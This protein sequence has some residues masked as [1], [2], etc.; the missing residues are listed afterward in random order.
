MS[1]LTLADQFLTKSQLAFLRVGFFDGVA[2]P[3]DYTL[4]GIGVDLMLPPKNKTGIMN[5]DELPCPLTWELVEKLFIKGTEAQGGTAVLS[6][7][8]LQ[9]L[10]VGT[11]LDTNV[12]LLRRVL[13]ANRGMKEWAVVSLALWLAS[14]T[15]D[16]LA[17]LKSANWLDY[18]VLELFDL[19]KP[20]L[21]QLRRT[22]HVVGTSKATSRELANKL[23]KFQNILDRNSDSADAEAEKYRRTVNTP[24]H[25]MPTKDGLDRC[26]W[27][28]SLQKH[29]G[30]ICRMAISELQNGN[31]E[32]VDAWWKSRA[33]WAP[34]GSSSSGRRAKREVA[35]KLIGTSDIDSRERANKKVTYCMLADDAYMQ[36]L[37]SEPAKFPRFSTKNEPAR[38]N[39][40]LYAEADTEFTVASYASVGIEGAIS[41]DGIYAKQAPEDV[42]EWV[43]K[44]HLY[45]QNAFFLSL[46]YSD[47]NTEHEL[48]TLALIDATFAIEWLHSGVKNEVKKHKA[49]SSIWTALSHLNSWVAFPGEEPTRILGGL[50]SGSRNTARD[51]CLLHYAYAACMDEAAKEIYP[52]FRKLSIMMT[53]DDEDATFDTWLSALAYLLSHGR[54]QFTVK[55]EK[56]MAGDKHNPT[57]EYLQRWLDSEGLPTQPICA[58]LAQLTSGNWY[59]TN[60]RW[61][62]TLIGEVNAKCWELHVRG[63]P[64]VVAQRI[65]RKILNRT[66]TAYNP[67]TR[68]IEKLEWWDCR[69]PVGSAPLWGNDSTKTIMIKRPSPS[70]LLNSSKG[71]TA[72]AAKQLKRF[73]TI[74][75]NPHLVAGLQ[76]AKLDDCM[77]TLVKYRDNRRLHAAVDFEQLRRRKPTPSALGK[78]IIPPIPQ[79]LLRTLV[80]SSSPRAPLTKQALINSYGVDQAVVDAMGGLLGFYNE[81]T[82]GE[83]S[84]FVLPEKTTQQP[85]QWAW[86]LDSSLRAHVTALLSF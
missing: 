31:M 2:T 48:P 56:Q 52:G 26:K 51:N 35:K 75:T 42:A 58:V 28:M 84:R 72:W 81:L 15:Q 40:A 66:M 18:T 45:E 53:G 34:S 74:R 82:P 57:H 25:Y 22:Q 4:V 16:A 24:T 20:K 43:H 55:P 85:P 1:V 23:R 47:Y 14:L 17:Y 10:I 65:A 86:L 27:F 19:V 83:R 38:K 70:K 6:I 71:S 21:S 7:M 12:G 13:D 50:F 3:F 54:A 5:R 80:S 8:D 73:E 32:D 36:M 11:P 44:H 9:E 79:K 77:A 68:K 62:D 78:P 60:Y 64:L 30:I 59:K 33:A 41:Q 29:L 39:R 69:Q 67:N 61:L 46:D 76:N 49:L 63:M 37:L